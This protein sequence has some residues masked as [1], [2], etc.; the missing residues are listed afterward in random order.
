MVYDI[1][2]DFFGEQ[3]TVAGL[4]TGQDIEA[5]LK[6]RNLGERLLLPQCIL[7]SGEDVFL[8][9]M[10]VPDLEKS[11]QVPI[12]IV[13]SSGWDFVEAVMGERIYE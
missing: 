7:R 10:H 8:D 2:N 6:D 5:Q 12:D 13:K 11:L 3:I 1:R 4:L 9:D